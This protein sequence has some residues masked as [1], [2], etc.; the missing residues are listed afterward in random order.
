MTIEFD[1]KS[2]NWKVHCP[3]HEDDP[4]LIVDWKLSMQNM[5]PVE[6]MSEELARQQFP[7]ASGPNPYLV[8]ALIEMI[9]DRGYTHEELL[10][11]SHS[12][13]RKIAKVVADNVGTIVERKRNGETS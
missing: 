3:V 9:C 13:I 5:P 1:G 7:E 6:F 11:C 2:N 4:A 10:T 12:E 8:Y